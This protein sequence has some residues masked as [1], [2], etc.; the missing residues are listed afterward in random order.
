MVRALCAAV[1]L[2]GCAVVGAAND[3][4]TPPRAPL[5]GPQVPTADTLPDVLV[6]QVEVRKAHVRVAE[7]GL[8]VAK[9]KLAR[10]TR[11]KA[12]PDEV[13]QGGLDVQAAT[14]HLDVRKA[15][16]GEAEARLKNAKEKPAAGGSAVGVFNMA[17]VM[18]QY[19]RARYQVHLLNERRQ[20]ESA[21]VVKMRTEYTRVEK[22]HA[23][24]FDADAKE[25]HAASLKT[26]GREIQDEDARVNKLLNSEASAIIST[27]Y[28]EMTAVVDEIAEK[29][30]YQL[31]FAYPDAVTP[32]EKKNPF[33]KELK[34]KPPAAQPFFVAKQLDITNDVVAG[35]NTKF[36]AVDGNG[37]KVDMSKIPAIPTPATPVV[38]KRD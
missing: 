27:I 15:E 3:I 14:A 26:L 32:E 28:D 4:P 2:V 33:L 5:A 19:D 9:A 12:T 10:L 29:K 24:E 35:L 30:G 34:L 31:V 6:A 16:L 18:R 8:A 21:A 7:V 11:G 25:K 17:T 23:A 13:E 36:P 1:V 20:V 38:P 22:Q 37:N